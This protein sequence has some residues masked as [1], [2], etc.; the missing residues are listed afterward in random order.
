[1]TIVHFSPAVMAYLC[2]MEETWM[3]DL[4]G[5]NHCKIVLG[6]CQWIIQ[7]SSMQNLALHVGQGALLD[8]QVSGCCWSWRLAN[9]RPKQ[10]RHHMGLQKHCWHSDS[11]STPDVWQSLT[12][13]VF[14]GTRMQPIQGSNSCPLGSEYCWLSSAWALKVSR[15]SSLIVWWITTFGEVLMGALSFSLK[16]VY[17]VELRLI[18]N[19]LTAGLM[20]S[21]L[22]VRISMGEL[23]SGLRWCCLDSVTVTWQSLCKAMSMWYVDTYKQ[24]K[25]VSVFE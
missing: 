10:K 16:S 11:L 21:T 14:A 23:E 3:W 22:S 13:F 18:L 12:N 6:S 5:R 20:L 17:S 8:N 19:G 24:E 15:K 9:H 25:K 2:H 7:T 4:S 1:M